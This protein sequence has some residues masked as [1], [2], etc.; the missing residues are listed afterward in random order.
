[1]T[2]KLYLPLLMAIWL[3]HYSLLAAKKWVNYQL[4]TSLLLRKCWR[5]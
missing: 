1:M 5:Q 4:I 2:K 3:L